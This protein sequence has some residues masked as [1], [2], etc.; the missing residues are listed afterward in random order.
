MCDV[1]ETCPGSGDCF[2]ANATPGC[3]DTSCCDLVC[4]LDAFC[5][6]Q[7]W[8]KDCVVVALNNCNLGL[9]PSNGDFDDN[10][11]IDFFDFREFANCF[12]GSG[13]GPVEESCACGDAD[14]D[15]EVDLDDFFDKFI[16]P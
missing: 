13:G 16:L 15:T 14:G 10:G 7:V 5:C 2:E 12:T 1:P 3:N 11:A 8:D 6:D 4:T 9:C